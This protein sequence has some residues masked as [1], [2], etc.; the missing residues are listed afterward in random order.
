MLQRLRPPWTTKGV[1]QKRF[2]Q[3]QRARGDSTFDRDPAP[4]IVDELPLEDGI[5]MLR[6]R[7]DQLRGEVD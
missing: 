7:P 4:Q 6:H 1:T 5:A 2:H 3:F